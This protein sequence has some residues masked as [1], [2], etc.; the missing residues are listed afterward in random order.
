MRRTIAQCN[1]LRRAVEA[2][3]DELSSDGIPPSATVAPGRA[4]VTAIS[5]AESSPAS[6][7]TASTPLP[8][9]ASCTPS[10]ASSAPAGIGTVS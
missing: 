3:N 1:P 2:R 7:M 8:D 10:L 6:S 4:A 5:M 9:V